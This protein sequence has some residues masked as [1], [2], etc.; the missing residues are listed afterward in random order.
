M[1]YVERAHIISGE[2]GGGTVVRLADVP[3][4]GYRWNCEHCSFLRV[5]ETKR[6]AINSITSHMLTTHHVCPVWRPEGGR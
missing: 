2:A 4:G 5:Y 6:G 3:G 1:P